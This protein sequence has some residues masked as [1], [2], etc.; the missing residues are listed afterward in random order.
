VQVVRAQVVTLGHGREARAELRVTT[1]QGEELRFVLS[2]LGTL[3]LA[4]T[5]AA[6]AA[7]TRRQKAP[8]EG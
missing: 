5:A 8:T 7:I 2:E 1:L 6:T 3:R 4:E